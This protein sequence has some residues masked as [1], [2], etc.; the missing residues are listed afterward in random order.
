MPPNLYWPLLG[1]YWPLLTVTKK[2]ASPYRVGMD[3]VTTC[4]F[5]PLSRATNTPAAGLTRTVA[6]RQ[7]DLT[8]TRIKT[9]SFCH[10]PRHRGA[11]RRLLESYTA[12]MRTM[13]WTLRVVIADD[14]RAW[15]VL[16]A[17]KVTSQASSVSSCVRCQQSLSALASRALPHAV[18][19]WTAA[20]AAHLRLQRVTAAEIARER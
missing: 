15:N 20:R 9:S 11:P 3:E 10:V 1:R 5:M 8:D 16:R 7:I 2:V 17:S 13:W 18:S 6:P 14:T 19:S 4:R 12:S